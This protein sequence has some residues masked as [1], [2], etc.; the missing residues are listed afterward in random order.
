MEWAV[1]E[2]ERR[3]STDREFAATTVEL[4]HASILT[5][6]R[7]AGAK[8]V[9]KPLHIDRPWESKPEPVRFGQFM[10]SGGALGR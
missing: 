4:L 8:N 10:K 5:N 6:M 3:W 7:I 2:R 9:G 1:A